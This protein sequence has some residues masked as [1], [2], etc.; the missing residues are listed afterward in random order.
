MV[1]G[2]GRSLAE[3]INEGERSFSFEFFP[4]K[5]EAGE[6]QLWNA[7][8][9]LEP[10]RPTFV[11]VTYGAGGSTRDKT[12]AITGRIAAET[13][14]LPVAHLT[15][16]GHTRDEVAGILDSYAAKGV[17]HVMALRGDPAEGPRADWT[18][19]PGG[20][21]YAIDVVRLARE[22]GDFRIGVAAF[23]EG[24]PSAESLETDADV[25]VAK[26]EAGAEFA[27]TQMFFRAA[28][29]FGLVD[30]VRA[31]GVD[32]PILPGIMPILNLAAIRRQ[33]ELIG[34]Q[35]PEEIVERLTAAGPEPA[36]IRAEGIA[37]AAEL[38]QELL[39]GGAPGL[40]FYTLNRSK[41]TLEI[42]AKLNVTP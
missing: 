5:D 17:E 34:A 31:R 2:R 22:R 23:P 39:D 12:V 18:P 27:V 3:L 4:P 13:E 10:Y 1:T 40:H 21:D 30:R 15:C 37:V 42:F 7:I 11:S 35:V 14:L 19:T 20:L 6:E 16:V 28:D 8:R 36:D 25:L 9:T 26:A 41:A 33:S 24:H 38:C 29:Y 32:I